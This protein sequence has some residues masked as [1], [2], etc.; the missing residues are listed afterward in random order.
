MTVDTLYINRKLKIKK[1]KIE[2][3]VCFL[4][5]NLYLKILEN[6]MQ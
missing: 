2:E 1:K 6:K 4:I 5:Y 3:P